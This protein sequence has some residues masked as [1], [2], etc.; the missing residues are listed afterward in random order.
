MVLW[1]RTFE[2]EETERQE[3]IFPVS[4]MSILLILSCSFAL[5]NLDRRNKIDRMKYGINPSVPASIPK[6]LL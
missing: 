6:V 3:W 2:H 5:H 1:L 4:I